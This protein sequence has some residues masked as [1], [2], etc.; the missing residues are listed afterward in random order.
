MNCLR[1]DTLSSTEL[2]QHFGLSYRTTF[3][4]N[5]LNSVLETA[6]IELTIPEKPNSSKLKTRTP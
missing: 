3:R 2:M 4:A 1:K 5:Y 6:L